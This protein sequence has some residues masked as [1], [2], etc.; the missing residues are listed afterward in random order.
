MDQVHILIESR[1]R[2][3]WCGFQYL[4]TA[5]VVKRRMATDELLHPQRHEQHVSLRLL[6][7]HFPEIN[8]RGR[9][10]TEFMNFIQ[11]SNDPNSLNSAA[12]KTLHR[13]CDRLDCSA[14]D[15]KVVYTVNKLLAVALHEKMK[16]DILPKS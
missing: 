12:L 2:V 3:G 13:T 9:V 4:M 10:F 6:F 16:N 14:A 5:F 7:F 15:R 8:G 1:T 11:F